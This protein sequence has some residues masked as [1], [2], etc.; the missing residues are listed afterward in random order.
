MIL[1]P[2]DPVSLLAFDPTIRQDER[3]RLARQLAVNDPFPIQYLPWLIGDDWMMVDTNADG[4]ADAWGDNYCILRLDFGT[5]FKYRGLSPLKLISER[6]GA[7]IELNLAVLMIGVTN[8]ILIGVLA[9]VH[10]GRPFDRYSRI[11]AALGDS[12]PVFWLGLL[13]I[14]FIGIVLPRALESYGIGN[15]SPFLPMGGR[16]SPIRGG[17]HPLTLGSTI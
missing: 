7:K 9:A 5:S 11:F 3:E 16:Y 1:A 14:V 6:L 8:G 4:T 2:G 13:S 15:G 12:I 17:C 10:R